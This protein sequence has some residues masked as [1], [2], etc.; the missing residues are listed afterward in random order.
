MKRRKIC[1]VTTSRADYG[2]MYW[3][4]REL[5]A[6]ARV[7]L[8]LVVA[9]MHFSSPHGNT[10]RQIRAAGF[11]PAAEIR[12]IPRAD[13]EEAI[14]NAIGRTTIGLAAAF[15]RLRPDL[16]VIL[17]DRYELLAVAS[18]ATAFRTPIAHLHG[19]ESTEGAIDDAIR[20]ALTKLS[21]LHLVAAPAY[22]ERVCGMGE[23]RWRVHV[24]GS[25]GLDHVTRSDLP[26]AA[27]VLSEL[28][29]P[30]NDPRPLFLVTLHP[31]TLQRGAAGREARALVS[32][33]RH[34]PARIV[35]TAPNADQENGAI[36]NAF[37][38][39]HG[40]RILVKTV[41]DLGS[42]RYL[43]L[44]RSADV[45]IGNSSSGFTEAPS[46]GTPVVNIGDRQKGRLRARNIID[47][48]ATVVGID[49]AIGRAL[50]AAFRRRATRAVNPYG[51]AGASA[52]IARL[53]ATVPLDDRLL[54]KCSAGHRSV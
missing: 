54:Q 50:S 40:R 51:G 14:A 24:V 36:S 45:L 19:G 5:E 16:V 47:A 10:Y 12:A 52:R 43:A 41:A 4:L 44:M 32:A 15:E 2:L 27:D 37:D 9:G 17:G 26:A 8:Q 31:A 49:A 22:G 33:L 53:L 6:D 3:M 13:S 30:A 28:G 23:Q 48:P 38:A 18:V 21:H 35:V 42:R 20:H 46:F 1:V 25:P 29:V 39:L 7:Q 11:V 34:R